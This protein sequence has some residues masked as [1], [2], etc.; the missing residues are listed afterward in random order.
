V[1]KLITMARTPVINVR[2]LMISL[3]TSI[4]PFFVGS[5]LIINDSTIDYYYTFHCVLSLMTRTLHTKKG[6]IPFNSAIINDHN[7]P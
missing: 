2:A 4:I 6:I 7:A 5:V 1:S 3:L